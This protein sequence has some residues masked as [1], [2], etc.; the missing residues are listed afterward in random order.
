MKN[1]SEDIL[2]KWTGEKITDYDLFLNSVEGSL[3]DIPKTKRKKIS[4]SLIELLQNAFKYGDRNPVSLQIVMSGKNIELE[5]QNSC[6][7][8]EAEKLQLYFSDILKLDSDEYKKLYLRNLQKETSISNSVGNGLILCLM[9]TEKKMQ[10]LING[11][12]NS[13]KQIIFKLFFDYVCKT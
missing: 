13:K 12:T 5:V 4:A 2:L 11:E 6:S 3:A 8:L 7:T 10:L 1:S 9:H